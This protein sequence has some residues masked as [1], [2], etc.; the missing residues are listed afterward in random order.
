M[1]QTPGDDVTYYELFEHY[2]QSYEKENV[3]INFD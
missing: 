3:N 2:I 1:L